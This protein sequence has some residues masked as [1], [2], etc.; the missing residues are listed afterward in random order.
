MCLGKADET[1]RKRCF[2]ETGLEIELRS[3]SPCELCRLEH[4][5]FAMEVVQAC[6]TAHAIPHA[7]VSM[8]DLL[9]VGPGR[10]VCDQRSKDKRG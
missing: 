1:R 8:E 4:V 5:K 2:V 9:S 3:A 10:A 6:E 7:C